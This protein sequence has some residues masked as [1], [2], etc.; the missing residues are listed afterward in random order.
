MLDSMQ[1]RGWQSYVISIMAAMMVTG[2]VAWFTFGNETATRDWVK[3]YVKTQYTI[4]H[5]LTRQQA[6]LIETNT[7]A[8]KELSSSFR[9]F[10]E[11]TQALQREQAE[12]NGMFRSFLRREGFRSKE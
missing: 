6:Q 12:L 8:M 4:M 11:D 7:Q 10:Q 9:A 5:E 1:P 3:D 2:L